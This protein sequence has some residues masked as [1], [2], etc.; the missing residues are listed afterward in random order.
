MACAGQYWDAAGSGHY[1]VL[2]GRRAGTLLAGPLGPPHAPFGARRFRRADLAVVGGGSA[3]VDRAAR[4]RSGTGAAA[5]SP[6]GGQGRLGGGGRQ[7]RS[8]AGQPHPW[9]GQRPFRMRLKHWLSHDEGKGQADRIV[10]PQAGC[11]KIRRSPPQGARAQ[12]AVRE[13]WRPAG[14]QA[15]EVP[16]MLQNDPSGATLMPSKPTEQTRLTAGLRV[17]ITS[18]A[19]L[20][21]WAAQSSMACVVCIFIRST[22][23]QERSHMP[24]VAWGGEDRA[25][26]R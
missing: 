17:L 16:G 4:P 9:R 24:R 18:S 22:L 2:A 26:G 19:F 14:A 12:S 20:T 5:S 11:H 15:P 21:S 25:R 8:G 10:L 3:A 13:A 1:Q 7:R 6:G 23:C